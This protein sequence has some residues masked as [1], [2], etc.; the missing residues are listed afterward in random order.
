MASTALRVRERI[1][2]ASKRIGR[3]K[4]IDRAAS[5]LVTFGGIFIIISVLFIFLF[6]AAETLPLFRSA[7]A[8]KLATPTL[9]GAGSLQGSS[10]LAIG[11]DEYQKYVYQIL[12]DAKV[13]FYR[14]DNG[15]LHLEIPILSLF[16][17]S[18]ANA[19]IVRRARAG[20]I[21]DPA[22]SPGIVS[23]I[24]GVLGEYR[25]GRCPIES[26]RTYIDQFDARLQARL[27]NSRL[28][29]LVAA[30]WAAS[31]ERDDH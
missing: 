26:D 28:R 15:V 7:S 4:R 13:A 6:I 1:V 17:D 24:E 3:V 16:R 21:V 11:I 5:A 19:S 8:E 14:A 29:A 18:E 12:P 2:E 9:G 20:P 27:L 25:L 31:D 30:R 23:A 22:D 10:A